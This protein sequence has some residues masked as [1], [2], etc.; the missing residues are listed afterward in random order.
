M[1]RLIIENE[2]ERG[3]KERFIYESEYSDGLGTLIDV[4]DIVYRILIMLNFPLEKKQ[5]IIEDQE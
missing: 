3:V 1:R 2:N 5:I 4:V